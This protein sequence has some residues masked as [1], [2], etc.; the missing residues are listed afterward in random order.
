MLAHLSNAGAAVS[1]CKIVVFSIS[2]AFPCGQR[3]TLV[4]WPLAKKG[5]LQ[6]LNTRWPSLPFVRSGF[7]RLGHQGDAS[8]ERAHR[9]RT[10][11][12]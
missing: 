11:G 1:A 9:G 7:C 3:S 6:A 8:T 10:E 4:F 12:A 2:Q 5:V